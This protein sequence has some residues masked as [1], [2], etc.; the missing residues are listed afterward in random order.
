MNMYCPNCG[1]YN[2]DQAPSCGQCNAPLNASAPNANHPNY[3]QPYYQQPTSAPATP[4]LPMKWFKFLIYFALFFGAIANIAT[5]AN[6]LTGK[7]YP[8]PDAVYSTYSGLQAIDIYMGVACFVLAAMG[9]ITRFRL[10]GYRK[11]G[12][13]FLIALYILTAV[14]NVLYVVAIVL[15]TSLSFNDLN[16]TTVITSV[17]TSA[18]MVVCNKTYFDKRKALFTK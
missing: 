13:S 1:S 4:E 12:P 18:I 11:D 15:F 3:Q 16:T 17:I 5:G 7:I 10:S 6:T 8:N 9:I 2:P 14:L